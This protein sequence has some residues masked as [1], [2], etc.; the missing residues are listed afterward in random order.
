[1]SHRCLHLGRIFGVMPTLAT[2]SDQGVK[3][4]E[5]E[6]EQLALERNRYADLFELA[7][8]AYLVTDPYGIIMEANAAATRLLGASAA[9]LRARALDL[10]IPLE[11]RGVFR[12][13][14]AAMA[15]GP[16]PERAAWRGSLRCPRADMNVEFTV[17]RI[18]HRALPMVSL[19]WFIRP[20]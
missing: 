8:D 5:L 19:C 18:R 12:G 6:V 10:F 14:L 17:G 13:K 7:P 2:E 4:P 1:M 16:G 3:T 9:G 20:L 11:Q 15:A